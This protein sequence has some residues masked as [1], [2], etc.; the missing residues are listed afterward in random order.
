MGLTASGTSGRP[1]GAVIPHGTIVDE[2]E[3]C[4]K[5]YDLG[6]ND[7]ILSILP[8]AHILERIAAFLFGAVLAGAE[9]DLGRGPEHM[10]EDIQV[11]RP[12]CMEAVPR[13]FENVVQDHFRNLIDEMHRQ[14][15]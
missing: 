4:L 5:A 2:V 15:A 6:P 14:A 10:L 8:C 13:L 7:V 1:K 3:S 11:V 12:T 9:L